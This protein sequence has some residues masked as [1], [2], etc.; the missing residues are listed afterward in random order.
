MKKPTKR[1]CLLF[2]ALPLA[3]LTLLCAYEYSDIFS[4]L[5][6][7]RYDLSNIP[8][9]QPLPLPLELRPVYNAKWSPTGDKIAIVAEKRGELPGLTEIYILDLIS[10][11]IDHI[12]YQGQ[13]F[14]GTQISWSPDGKRIATL[15][16]PRGKPELDG[17]WVIDIENSDKWFLTEGM[18][19]AWSPS[20]DHLIVIHTRAPSPYLKLVSLETQEE[21]TIY[22]FND[23]L[24]IQREE[25]NWSNSNII[26]LTVTEEDREGYRLDRLYLLSLEDLSLKPLFIDPG[27]SMYSPVWLPNNQWLAFVAGNPTAGT[28]SVAPITGDCILGWL[29]ENVKADSVDVSPD[30]GKVV[31]TYFGRAYI[32]DIEKVVGS[33]MLPE[34]LSCP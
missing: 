6:H 21:K 18:A 34:V 30:G 16:G 27:L 33:H 8:G 1:F 31:F 17:I 10:E 20:G 9:V 24:S 7:G 12:T 4:L 29:P 5:I 2:L 28:I 11:E 23:R 32:A 22:R 25:L 13:P 19:S 15:G 3:L 26:V 14:I